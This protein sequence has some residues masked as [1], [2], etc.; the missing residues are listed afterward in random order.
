MKKFFS[1]L[2]FF[3][4]PFTHYAQIVNIESLRNENNKQFNGYIKIAYDFKKVNEIDWEMENEI[5]LNWNYKSWTIYLINEINLDRGAGI[6]FSNDGFQHLRINNKINSKTTIESFFQNQYDPIRKIDNRIL[7]GGGLRRNIFNHYFGISSFFE[8]E[9]LN[10]STKENNL[11]LNS[12]LNLNYNLNKLMIIYSTLYFQPKI[13]SFNDYRFS[14]ETEITFKI[15]KKF[16][17]SNKI[18]I[19]YD[20]FP[21]IGIP[22]TLINYKNGFSYKF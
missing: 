15:S 12:Y 20:S 18:E 5:F 2:L 14:N 4:F 7:F 22:N 16:F 10:Y 19:S 8:Q 11:R 9:K 6:D 17:F 1:Y 13:N 21:A 3:L